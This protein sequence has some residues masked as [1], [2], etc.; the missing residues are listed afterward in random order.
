MLRITL[1]CLALMV[2]GTGVRAQDATNSKEQKSF[3]FVQGG[4]AIPLADFASADLTNE[5]AGMAKTG[6]SGSIQYNYRIQQYVG[7]MLQGHYANFAVSDALSKNFPGAT[8]DHWQ[9]AGLVV[10]PMVFLPV[11]DRVLFDVHAASGVM[12]TNSPKVK[13]QGQTIVDEDWGTAVPV[14]TGLSVRFFTN[15]KLVVFAGAD[16]LYM[17]PEF[18]IESS[19]PPD[20]TQKINALHVQLGIGFH[21]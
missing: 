9:Y 10:G 13:Y 6:F 18:R 20:V 2:L 17:K 1:L 4:V 19:D 16:Y 12:W 11:S 15:T 5:N 21:F 7:V 8:I 14:Q 3:L